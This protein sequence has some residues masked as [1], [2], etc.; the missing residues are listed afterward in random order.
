MSKLPGADADDGDEDGVE[1]VDHVNENDRVDAGVAASIR[2][3]FQWDYGS[4]K[5]EGH[6]PRILD[7]KT[8]Q[9]T[10]Y[11]DYSVVADSR[12]CTFTYISHQKRL[13]EEEFTHSFHFTLSQFTF[14]FRRGKYLEKSTSRI[15]NQRAQGR[16]LY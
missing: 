5:A 12:T 7:H 6:N 9:S 1:S 11:S 15:R 16:Q 13:K 8:E 14:L 10:P 4:D 3:E 2:W